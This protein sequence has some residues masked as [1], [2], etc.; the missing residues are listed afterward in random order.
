MSD[1]QLLPQFYTQ[2]LPSG[3]LCDLLEIVSNHP[4]YFEFTENDLRFI[5]DVDKEEFH[6]SYGYAWLKFH[7]TEQ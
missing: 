4:Y 7:Y 1:I 3:Y 6:K 5:A 2:K